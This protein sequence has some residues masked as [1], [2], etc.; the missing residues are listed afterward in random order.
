MDINHHILLIRI[1]NMYIYLVQ[2]NRTILVFVDII[3]YFL[4]IFALFTN[5]VNTQFTI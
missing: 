5:H 1:W 2:F 4:F 3:V